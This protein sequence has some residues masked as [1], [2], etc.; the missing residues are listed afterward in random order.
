MFILIVSADV[1]RI[2]NDPMD[3]WTAGKASGKDI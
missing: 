3:R 2:L 1:R